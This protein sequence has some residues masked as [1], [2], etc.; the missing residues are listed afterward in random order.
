[1]STDSDAPAWRAKQQPSTVFG[2]PVSVDAGLDIAVVQ[3]YDQPNGSQLAT[4]DYLS[5]DARD[6]ASLLNQH[7]TIVG[8]LKGPQEMD[9]RPGRGRQ[10]P[11]D[12]DHGVHTPRQQRLA[13]TERQGQSLDCCTEGPRRKTYSRRPASICT[14]GT[15]SAPSWPP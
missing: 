8:H 3:F 5:F 10:W 9:R 4:P 6:A 13:H 14:L 1:M 2:V 7:V 12:H 11:V 15:A